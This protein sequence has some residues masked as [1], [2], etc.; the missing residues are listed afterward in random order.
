MIVEFV[1]VNMF[2]R[3]IFGVGEFVYVDVILLVI[4][5]VLGN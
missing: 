4:F 1:K 5:V 3:L 2:G